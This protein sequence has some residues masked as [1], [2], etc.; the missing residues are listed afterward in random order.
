MFKQWDPLLQWR[1]GISLI[2]FNTW[3]KRKAAGPTESKDSK[4]V[5]AAS[6]VFRMKSRFVS[7]F[8]EQNPNNPQ[9]THPQTN[10]L[11]PLESTPNSMEKLAFSWLWIMTILAQF[12]CILS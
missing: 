1:R 9:K 3:E 12:L 10:S 7:L 8:T 2:Q 4:M 5:S 6:Q 11:H